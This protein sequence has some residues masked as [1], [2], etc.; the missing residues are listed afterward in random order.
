MTK[1]DPDRCR[2]HDQVFMDA[3][4]QLTFAKADIDRAY[5]R[6]RAEEKAKQLTCV[7]CSALLV[8][9]SEPPHCEDTCRPTEEH[10]AQWELENNE[11]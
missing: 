1:L 10:V 3:C 6:G 7:V 11:D 2:D 8:A 5:Q 9:N 4:A